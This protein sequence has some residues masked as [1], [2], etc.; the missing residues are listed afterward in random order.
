MISDSSF[1][2][3]GIERSN[4]MGYVREATLKQTTEKAG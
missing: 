3:K 4:E 1:Y 2:G